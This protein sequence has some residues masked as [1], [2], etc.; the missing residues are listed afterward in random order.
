MFYILVF[1]LLLVI[2]YV[3]TP[4]EKR[5]EWGVATERKMA[6]LVLKTTTISEGEVRYLE[7]GSGTPLLL[8]H[9]FGADKDN[10]VRMSKH[11]TGKYRV[12]A[13]DLPGFGESLKQPDL[14]YDVP[15]QVERLK[16]FVEAIGLSEFHIGGNSMGGYIAGNYAVEHPEQV[17]SLWL[18]NPLGVAT[19]PD[20]EMFAMLRQQERPAVLVGDA[21]QYKELLAFAFHKPPFIPGFIIKELAKRAQVSFPLNSQIF[22]QIHHIDDGQVHFTV[23]LDTVLEG[24]HKPTLITWGD[25]DRVLHVAGADI[26]GKLVPQS[27][28]QVMKDMGHLPMIEAPSQ[29]AKQFLQFHQA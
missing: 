20:S 21:E 28:V 18:L 26:L 25:N 19:S 12:I 8:L 1:I 10:W 13:P 14:N 27:E 9:G 15:A 22:Q 2:A 6:G 11:L 5:F 24:F 29:T 4:A 7:G 16:A 17:L 3:M 23:P